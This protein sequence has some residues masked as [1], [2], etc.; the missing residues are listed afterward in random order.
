MAQ[1]SATTPTNPRTATSVR[2]FFNIAVSAPEI[3]VLAQTDIAGKFDGGKGLVFGDGNTV[4]IVAMAAKQQS[5]T[6]Y[7]CLELRAQFLEGK[8]FP[9]PARDPET[10]QL[11]D[12]TQA[13]TMGDAPVPGHPG[14]T[15]NDF[16][17][18]QCS[19]AGD[20]NASAVLVRYNAVNG[21][22]EYHILPVGSVRKTAKGTFL[23]NHRFGRKG[24]KASDTTEHL[25]YDPDPKVVR[26]IVKRAREIDP[27]TKKPYGQPGQILYIYTPKSGE[28]DYPLPPHWAGLET[29]LADAAYQRYDLE[30][31]EGGFAA[32]GALAMI[33]EED[34]Q[35]ED[36]NG[37]TQQDRS[38]S[39]LELF[40]GAGA[41]QQ[42]M[43][44][45]SI[46]V[47]DVKSK[48]VVPVWIPMNTT[49]DLR[50]LSEK[51]EATGQEVCRHIGIP[52]I[53]CGFARPGQ[54]GA[55]QELV[56]AAQL[57]QN[58]LEPLRKAQL[59]GFWRLFPALAGIVPAPLNP[60]ELA[61][62]IMAQ[63]PATP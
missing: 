9:V 28:E 3:G 27:K 37:R 46:M 43:R 44:R 39:E 7:R 23:L 4:P 16:W 15:V 26:A 8:G 35:T 33:G 53:L 12:A 52:P 34:S 54:L 19:Y 36:E 50:W 32:K 31:V 6:T 49:V 45:K 62:Q 18:E 29:C 13:G 47:F 11:L 61:T 22:G 42:G 20:L 55:V 1:P 38:T 41:R 57:T 56:N 14:K 48:D 25:P 40:T 21:P 2:G 58:S 5:G 59:R 30:E 24:F 63:T 17:A 60:V 51:K 10:G